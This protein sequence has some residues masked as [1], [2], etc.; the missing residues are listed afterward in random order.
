MAMTVKTLV[1]TWKAL[2]RKK[3]PPTSLK[4]FR[5]KSNAQDWHTSSKTKWC[6]ASVC[7]TPAPNGQGLSSAKALLPALGVS[8]TE[9]AW[10]LKGSTRLPLLGHAQH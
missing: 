7:Y 8:I 2:N 6:R 4:T 5:I 3:G 9:P 10:P 1:S